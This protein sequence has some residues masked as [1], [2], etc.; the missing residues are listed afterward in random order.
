LWR[1]ANT[2]LKVRT[3]QSSIANR[4]STIAKGALTLRDVKNEDRSGYMHEN[5]GNNDKMS[6]GKT[7]FYTKMHPFHDNRQQSVGLIGRKCTS[8]VIIRGEVT[9]LE[10]A[11]SGYEGPRGG[12]GPAARDRHG[13]AGPCHKDRHVLM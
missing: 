6:G 11:L 1:L 13:Q 9:P 8:H 3:A 12:T 7:G 10:P 4:Q 2:F 5:T